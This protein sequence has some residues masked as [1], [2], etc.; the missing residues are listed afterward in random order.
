MIMKKVQKKSIIF[1]ISEMLLHIQNVGYVLMALQKFFMKYG[2]CI[3]EHE[4]IF[5]QDG[6]I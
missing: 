2:G 6:Y 3:G 1:G 5:R 4:G